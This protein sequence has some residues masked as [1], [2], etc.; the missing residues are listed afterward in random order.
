MRTGVHGLTL[1]VQRPPARDRSGKPAARYERGLVADSPVGAKRK[2]R[3][4][5]F[6]TNFN[7]SK[8]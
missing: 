4:I 7:F 2:G 1:N 8:S 5:I 6:S 3:K